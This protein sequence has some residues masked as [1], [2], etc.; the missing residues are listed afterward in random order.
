MP[1]EL[2]QLLA[3]HKQAK[4]NFESMSPGRQREYAEYIAAAK[5]DDT[6]QRRLKKIL[7]MLAAGEGLNDQYR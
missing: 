1:P 5:R 3:K 4:A 7:P 6:K 2:Q